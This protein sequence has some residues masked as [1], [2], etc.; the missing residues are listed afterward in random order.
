MKMK[1]YYIS[2]DLK[3]PDVNIFTDRPKTQK[4]Y[5]YELPEAVQ[6]AIIQR[7]DYDDISHITKWFDGFFVMTKYGKELGF[8]E[9][10]SKWSPEL[11]S[12][13]AY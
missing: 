2:E 11:D 12:E 5:F 3:V 9:D 13:P 8:K 7:I 10:G 1:L 4:L 6:K